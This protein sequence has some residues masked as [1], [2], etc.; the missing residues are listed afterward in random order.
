MVV[1]HADE[2]LIV[3]VLQISEY[4]DPILKRKM[5]FPKAPSNNSAFLESF[6]QGNYPIPT[7]K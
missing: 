4:L 5:E 3:F 1:D 2:L 7:G 6:L